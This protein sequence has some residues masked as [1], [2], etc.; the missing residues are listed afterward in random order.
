MTNNTPISK[1]NQHVESKVRSDLLSVG[2]ISAQRIEILSA[3]TRDNPSLNVY[4]DPISKVIFIDDYYIGNTEY[5]SGDYR[6]T[7]KP[8]PGW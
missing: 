4:R 8:L 2:A 1:S 7:P 6:N 5:I 3:K